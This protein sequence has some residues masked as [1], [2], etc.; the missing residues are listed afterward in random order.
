MRLVPLAAV[1]L[2]AA[3]TTGTPQAAQ[4]AAAV[5]AQATVAPNTA[6][7]T[8]AAAAA[9]ARP[10]PAG[11]TSNQEAVKEVQAVRA[12]YEEAQKAYTAGDK[13][14][15]LDVM[16]TAYLDHFERIEPWM[17]Q[18]LG[19]EY[20]EQVEASISR[21]LRRKLRD[22]PNADVAAQVPVGLKNLQEA[23]AKLAAL[24]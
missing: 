12:A 6:A 17:D 15:A 1:F 14:K 13:A 7:G 4:P 3:C 24:P 5:P 19:K 10:K 18:K 21:E 2:I 20:R 23:E 8:P 22:N 16:N 9:T 11:V